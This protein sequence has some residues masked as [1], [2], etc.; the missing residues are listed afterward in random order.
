MSGDWIKMRGNLWD[1]PRVAAICDDTDSAECA[2]IGALYW[3]WAAA[4]QHTEDGVLP[5]L[6]LR[7]IDRK[8]GVPGFS[9]AVVRVGWIE[10]IDGGVRI[11]RFEEHNGASAKR[12]GSDAKRKASVRKLSASD[13]DTEKTEAGRDAELEKEK[14]KEIDQ[15]QK[16]KQERGSPTGS[17]L[18][19]D[20]Q[21][22]AADV[23]FAER[24][25]SDVD[26]RLEA[27][28]FADYWHG[29]AGAKGRKSDWPGTWRNWIRRADAPRG[30]ARAGPQQPLGKQMQGVMTLEGMI[31]ERM[32]GNRNSEGTPAAGLLVAGS[33]AGRRNAAGNGERLD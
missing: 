15:V 20:W 32:A 4:D 30:T 26:W 6:S 27:E 8:T 31:R 33:D 13:A 7:Q 10:E 1:D 23:A 12:R 29:I 24:E 28:K 5:G 2:V 21:P 3:L 14:E 11:V 18:P 25:R 9:A 16:Q 19:A 17:L 22:S